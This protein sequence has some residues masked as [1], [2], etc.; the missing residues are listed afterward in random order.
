MPWCRRARSQE[1]RAA[2]L[3]QLYIERCYKLA[4]EDYAALADL[5]RRIGE[6][7]GEA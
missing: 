7:Q 1:P 2:Q 3:A 6:L 4:E 5:D